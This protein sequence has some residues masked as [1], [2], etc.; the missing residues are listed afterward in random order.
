[1]FLP[2]NTLVAVGPVIVENNRVLLIRETKDVGSELL[3]LP[4]GKVEEFLAPLEQT[5]IREA[6]E[7]LGI[8]ITIMRP[9]DTHFVERPSAPGQYAVLVHFLAKRT[10][11]SMPVVPTD[12]TI[13]WGWYDLENL[14]DHVAPNISRAVREYLAYADDGYD[15]NDDLEEIDQ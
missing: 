3:M 8:D 1:M 10:D 9:L 15:L 6:K 7:E 5:A 13:E 4:G 14:P 12:K 2:P 11:P